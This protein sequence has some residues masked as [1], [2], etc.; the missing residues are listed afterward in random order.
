MS[1]YCDIETEKP[2]GK[3]ENSSRLMQQVVA[4]L[5]ARDI[6]LNTQRAYCR[7]IIEF[8]RF[9]NMIYPK[10]LGHKNIKEFLDYLTS[11]LGRAPATRHQALN[12]LI[13]LY[14]RVLKRNVHG[15]HRSLHLQPSEEGQKVRRTFFGSNFGNKASRKLMG[16]FT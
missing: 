5:K 14:R 9:H 16:R 7:W 1:D 4:C 12:A 15:W 3:K 6:S 8:I 2:A 13:F 11:S 10:Q